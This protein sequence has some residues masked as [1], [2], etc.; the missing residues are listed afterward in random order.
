[1]CGL[2]Q[3]LSVSRPPLS[4]VISSV[5]Q[6]V[7]CPVSYRAVLT[8]RHPGSLLGAQVSAQRRHRH[9][10]HLRRLRSRYQVA[11]SAP[12]RLDAGGGL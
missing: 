9:P 8:A 11:S 7:S 12:A 2:K 5:W 1:M 3:E 4:G 6:H 10:P